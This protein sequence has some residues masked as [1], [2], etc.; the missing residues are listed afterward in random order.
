MD[1]SRPTFADLEAQGRRPS[2]FRRFLEELDGWIPWGAWAARVDPFYPKA[3]NGRPPVPLETML[4]MYALQVAYQL[5]DEAAEDWLCEVAAA[6]SFV[7]CTASPDATTLCRFRHLLE[8]HGLGRELFEELNA[9]LEEGGVRMCVGTIVDATFVE[10]PSSTKSARKERDPEGH[11]S[12]KGQNWHFGYKAHVGVDAES[13]TVHSLEVTAANA[14]DLSQAAALVRE[15]DSDVWADAGYTGVARWVEGTP[16]AGAEWHVARRK[17]SVPEAE[18]PAESLLASVRS[19]VEHAFHA[20]KDIIGLRKTRYR[21]AAKVEN[22]LY[23]AFAI[24]N[25]VLAD[26]RRRLEGP[27]TCAMDSAGPRSALLGALRYIHDLGCWHIYLCVH[28]RSAARGPYQQPAADPC[29]RTGPQGRRGPER[30]RHEGVGA[31]D[32]KRDT[33][34]PSH[35][36]TAALLPVFGHRRG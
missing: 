26:R 22:Q 12:K 4:R 5:S 13:G 10:S 33:P 9:S 19:R 20:L 2:R 8:E 30:Q 3:G 6:R 31:A 32:K 36:D 21:G 1:H 15:G 28:D 16:V 34:Q 7:G 17:G 24:A 18:R 25:C 35:W 14:S 11:Q 27:P 23:A 29:R